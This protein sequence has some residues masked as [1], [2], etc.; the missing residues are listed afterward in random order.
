MVI[1]ASPIVACHK[2]QETAQTH[3]KEKR[4]SCASLQVQIRRTGRNGIMQEGM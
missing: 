3:K 1:K 4:E 2:H